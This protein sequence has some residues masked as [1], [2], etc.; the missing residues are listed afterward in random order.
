MKSI[1]I[2][3]EIALEMKGRIDRD[4][5]LNSECTEFIRRKLIESRYD[6]IIYPNDYENQDGFDPTSYIVFQAN[7]IK[8]LEPTYENGNLIPLSRRFDRNSMK[9][10]H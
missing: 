3:K 10:T 4:Q 7:Q 5:S 8:S 1:G 6:A 2:D 9:F